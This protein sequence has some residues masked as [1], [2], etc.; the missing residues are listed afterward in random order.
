MT[1]IR[2]DL[3][4]IALAGILVLV[5][6]GLS[7]ALGLGIERKLLVASARMV[8]QLLLV[9]LVLTWLF[10]TVSL[11]L[12][13]GVALVMVLFAGHEITARQDRRLTGLWGYGLG[14]G[15][16][17]LAAGV[18]TLFALTTQ[19]KPDPWYDPRYAIPLLGM[20]LGNT[21]TGIALGLNTLTANVSLRRNAI[22]ARLALGDTRHQ[23]TMP[24]V[25]QAL[26]TAL[27]PII[28]SMAATGVVSLPGMMT[29]QILGGVDP[30]EAVKYQIL[31]MFLIA[32]GTGLGA[33]AAVLGGI[34]RLTDQRHRV[35]LDRLS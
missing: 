26:S 19:L 8:V 22:E 27:T 35:R 1:Y 21:M 17:L 20:V 30:V 11:W 10:A 2:L 32:G 24:V 6:G 13:L 4:D 7:L 28:N 5:N 33:V 18:V 15:C 12:T 25:R 31:I 14:T 23:A 3:L 9:G 16:M 34:H 29:G